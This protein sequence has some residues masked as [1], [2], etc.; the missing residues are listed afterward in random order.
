MLPKI[1]MTAVLDLW[2]KY[3][4]SGY[5]LSKVHSEVAFQLGTSIVFRVQARG[6]QGKAAVGSTTGARPMPGTPSL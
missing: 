5:D 3:S 1:V 6:R 4:S 2:I